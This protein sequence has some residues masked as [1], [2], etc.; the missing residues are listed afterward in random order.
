[1][2]ILL[3]EQRHFY[4]YKRLIDLP[5]ITRFAMVDKTHMYIYMSCKRKIFKRILD[6]MKIKIMTLEPEL[7]LK[8]F[9]KRGKLS[10]F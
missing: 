5:T 1:M 6:N 8:S 4:V 9:M 2:L 3:Y 10:Y 7:V